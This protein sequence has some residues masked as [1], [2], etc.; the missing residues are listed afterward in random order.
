MFMNLPE[1]RTVLSQGVQDGV[2][3]VGT[4]RHTQRLQTVTPPT[5]GD[6]SLIC[7]LLFTRDVGPERPEGVTTQADKNVW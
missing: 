1:A 2:R 4:A 6:E 7:D 5:N 3:D